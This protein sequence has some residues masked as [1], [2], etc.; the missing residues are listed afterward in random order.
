M[1]A[2]TLVRLFSTVNP[3]VSVQVIA[4]NEPHL[5]RV[6]SKWFFPWNNH[7]GITGY[8]NNNYLVVNNYIILHDVS[9]IQLLSAIA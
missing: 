9:D 4:L 1:A 6:T 3:L 7:I 5:T 2:I 8:K